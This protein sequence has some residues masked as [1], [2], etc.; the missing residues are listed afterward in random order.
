M[1]RGLAMAR[2]LLFDCLR[3]SRI[4]IRHMVENDNSSFLQMKNVKNGT[5][6]T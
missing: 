3:C 5:D 6:I 4:I 1:I 2:L